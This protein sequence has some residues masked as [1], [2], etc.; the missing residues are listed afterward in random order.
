MITQEGN[1]VWLLHRCPGLGLTYPPQSVVC[2]NSRV[3]RLNCLCNSSFDLIK[4]LVGGGVIDTVVWHSGPWHP[5]WE[6]WCHAAS[7]TQTFF[8]L[9]LKERSHNNSWHRFRR[10]FIYSIRGLIAP[11]KCKS[12]KVNFWMHQTSIFV[13]KLLAMAIP[14]GQ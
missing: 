11:I 1:C 8:G 3:A 13:G 6:S 10:L 5:R 7:K 14:N 9:R 4:H 2:M 12:R